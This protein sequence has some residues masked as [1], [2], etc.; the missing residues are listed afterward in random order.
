MAVETQGWL[1]ISTEG[2]ASMNAARPPEH[3]VK[4]L[5]QNSLDSIPPNYPGRIQL[6]YGMRDGSF[7]VECKDDGVGIDNL[8]DLRVV[9]LTNK[10]DTHLKRGRF[11]RGFKEALCIAEEAI[12]VSKCQQIQFLCENE[13]RITK[14]ND[15]ETYCVR[16]TLVNMKMPWSAETSEILDEYF[17]TF[18]IPEGVSVFL[19]DE[20]INPRSSEHN[21]EAKLSTEIYSFE[22]QNWKKPVRKTVIKLIPTVGDETAKIYEMGI[23]V[24]DVEWTLPLHCDVQQRIPMNPNR[25][26]VASGYA[27]KLHIA[28]LPILL[29]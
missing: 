7:F 16:G 9:Y 15:L 28:C 26:A 1:S 5:L 27:K 21:V 22:G 18:L 20:L 13:Q 4:E 8:S 19:N 10:T 29:P 11:G 6:S 25:D 3:L 23:P 12:V 14:I 2:F 17:R 24:A